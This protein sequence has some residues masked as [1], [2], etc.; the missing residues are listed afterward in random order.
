M[1]IAKINI[2]RVQIKEKAFFFFNKA[3]KIK[4]NVISTWFPIQFEG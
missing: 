4:Y 2:G 3:S 1:K